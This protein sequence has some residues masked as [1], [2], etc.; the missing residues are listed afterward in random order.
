MKNLITLFVL[1]GVF[2]IT[3][4]ADVPVLASTCIGCH[5]ANGIS[6]NPLWPNLAGQKKEYLIK[7][8][9][10]FKSNER[11]DPLMNPLAASLKEADMSQIA[12]YFSSLDS[13]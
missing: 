10:A 6:P 12:E 1:F 3:A 13:K 2:S 5:G 8:L 4:N 7:Q 11:K 9:R